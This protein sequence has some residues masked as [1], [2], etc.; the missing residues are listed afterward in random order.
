VL[1]GPAGTLQVLAA[2]EPTATATT[3]PDFLARRYLEAIAAGAAAR[4]LLTS[5]ASFFDPAAAGLHRARFDEAV[6][7]AGVAVMRGNTNTTPRH[8]IRWC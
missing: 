6:G 2:L 4:L 1:N 7:A 5:K 3:L 8:A